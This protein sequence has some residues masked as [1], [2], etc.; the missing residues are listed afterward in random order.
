MALSTDLSPANEPCGLMSAAEADLPSMPSIPGPDPANIEVIE[1]CCSVACCG[2]RFLPLKPPLKLPDRI[3]NLRWE[4]LSSVSSALL[5]I[6]GAAS[7]TSAPEGAMV[8]TRR[9]P[10]G[11]KDMARRQPL[12]R[13]G[14]RRPKPQ[15]SAQ[16]NHTRHKRG[17]DEVWSLVHVPSFQTSRATD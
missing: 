9:T 1:F 13:C 15:S 6:F 5:T 7:V 12:Q 2:A 11:K 17:S 14:G 4:P 10:D 3:R 16:K 8:D